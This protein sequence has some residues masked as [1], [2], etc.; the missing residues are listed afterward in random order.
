MIVTL[1]SAEWIEL[2]FGVD[3]DGGSGTLEWGIVGVLAVGAFAA[4]GFARHEWRRTAQA[5]GRDA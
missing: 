2:L 5:F 4:G 3:P 1:I